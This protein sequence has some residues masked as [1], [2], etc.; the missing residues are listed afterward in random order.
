[1]P[2]LLFTRHTPRSTGN[3]IGKV[4]PAL[5]PR[6]R[7]CVELAM[8]TD[9]RLGIKPTTNGIEHQ[10]L[11]PTKPMTESKLK[12][13]DDQLR[14]PRAHEERVYAVAHRQ[15]LIQDF[16]DE[17]EY[18]V[19]FVLYATEEGERMC[20]EAIPAGAGD[21]NRVPRISVASDETLRPADDRV[22][23]YAPIVQRHPEVGNE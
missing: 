4:A 6:E 8:S 12:Q 17:R 5:G 7:G 10:A 14:E 16:D 9:T 18:E 20:L 22:S 13:C 2:I 23:K 15:G 3:I 11:E 1:M 19:M 21:F